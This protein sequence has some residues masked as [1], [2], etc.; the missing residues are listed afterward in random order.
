[1]TAQNSIAEKSF[2]GRYF[3]YKLRTNFNYL[4]F[5]LIFAFLGMPVM[6]VCLTYTVGKVNDIVEGRLAEYK[7]YAL[8]NLGTLLDAD[9]FFMALIFCAIAVMSIITVVSVFRY[10]LKKCDSDLYLSLPLTN[11]QR[12]FADLGVGAVISVAPTVIMGGIA[13]VVTALSGTKLSDKIFSASETDG[14]LSICL[15]FVNEKTYLKD[16]AGIVFFVFITAVTALV[17][18]YLTAVLINACTGRTGDSVVYTILA[19]IVAV[20]ATLAVFAPVFAVA[21]EQLDGYMTDIFGK[22]PPLGTVLAAL[23]SF[24]M[25]KM[26]A[27]NDVY[28]NF[29]L[30]NMYS[31]DTIVVLVI[32]AGVLVLLAYLA[33]KYRKAE[34]TGNHFAFE[35]AYHIITL[36]L[37]AGII[38]AAVGISNMTVLTTDSLTLIVI[39]SL[40]AVGYF[41]AE[42]AHGRKLK[43]IWQSVLRF[44][45]TV[46]A[47]LLLFTVLNNSGFRDLF[48]RVPDAS[49]VS[50]ASASY[51]I[52]YCDGNNDYKTIYFED[53]ESKKAVVDFNK[54]LVDNKYC[55]LAGESFKAERY[56]NAT[57]ST[58]KF[59]Y[60]LKN[61]KKV[62]RTYRLA[63]SSENYDAY[64]KALYE[65]RLTL[66]K[67]DL[68][69]D[70]FKKTCD[71]ESVNEVFVFEKGGDYYGKT[72]DRNVNQKLFE[73]IKND[74]KAGKNSGKL[75]Y[76]LAF[77]NNNDNSE[78]NA[79]SLEIRENC[80][81]T[82]AL[83]GKSEMTSRKDKFYSAVDAFTV[84]LSEADKDTY[85]L[86][87]L[88][89]YNYDPM[90]IM[91][92]DFK[93]S[94]TKK[95]I[96]MSTL[97]DYYTDGAADIECYNI[98]S[99]WWWVDGNAHFYIP[100]DKTSDAER[101]IKL[102]LIYHQ[103]TTI[104]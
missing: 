55:F 99:T 93:Y 66:S 7:T 20:F 34:N 41:F 72:L 31:I 28:E 42:L 52:V 23:I 11:S 9:T 6:A 86:M 5:N 8:N 27:Y 36:A 59:S 18:V 57:V 54:F 88:F 97:Y 100:R 4:V 90:D 32:S 24:L 60:R 56:E 51:N 89:S 101:L 2:F 26:N 44:V 68:Y 40:C 35:P 85:T 45:I 30:F 64:A 80:T 37:I 15:S 71:K 65:L 50:G 73:A 63:L 12:F 17:F 19:M 61:G 98:G 78:Y 67:T 48:F 75:V 22:V 49:E 74:Y 82:I 16:I 95:L 39:I 43:K 58:V 91:V 70:T 69:Y 96:E 79:F 38:A 84:S 1:M 77:C 10:N 21:G 33:N 25:L 87:S 83:I 94:D 13:S 92:S 104:R 53:E 81:E 14:F 62:Y 46:V 3:L 29:N 76:R 102:L 103:P 47:S